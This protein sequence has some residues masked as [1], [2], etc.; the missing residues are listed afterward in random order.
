MRS[1]IS[2]VSRASRNA[3]VSSQ[4]PD[5]LHRERGKVG[6][7]GIERGS[8]DAEPAGKRGAVLVERR[9]GYPRAV[10]ARVVR[11]A[12]REIRI[13]AVERAA[14]HRTAHDEMRRAP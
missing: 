8:G 6:K 1:S 5:V 2:T 14:A 4:E 3:A 9:I 12:H 11:P 7:H 10:I 13:R